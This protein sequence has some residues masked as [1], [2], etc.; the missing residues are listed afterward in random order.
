MN[1][2]RFIVLFLSLFFGLFFGMSAAALPPPHKGT[3]SA[4][5]VGAR[6]SSVSQSR[7]VVLY[8]D[9]QIDPVISLFFF[10]EKIAFFGSSMHYQQFI[11]DDRV[12]FRT[13]LVSI[14]DNPLFPNHESVSKGDPDRKSTYEWSNGVD[15][16]FPGYNDD[17]QGEIELSLS[18]DLTLHGGNYVSLVGKVKLFEFTTLNTRVEPNFVGTTG[19]GDRAHNEYLYGPSDREAGIN[20]VSYGIWLAFPD[21]ADRYYPIV[22]LMRYQVVGDS[23]RNAEYARDRNEGFLFS[24]IATYPL[25]H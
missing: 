2:K 1:S 4:I 6:F 14:N 17:Y 24:V 13:R 15:L 22:Q 18:K 16:F 7:G 12:R 23:H 20:N 10:D 8:R 25:L 3:I 9:Y 21:R 11:V 19:W 5:N